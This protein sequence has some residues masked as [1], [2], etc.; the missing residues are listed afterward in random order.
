MHGPALTRAQRRTLLRR[1][2]RARPLENRASWDRASR[3][4]ARLRRTRL[5]CRLRPHRLRGRG[6]NRARS[7]LRHDHATRR[8]LGMR[9]GRRWRDLLCGLRHHRRGRLHC[10]RRRRRRRLRKCGR[11]RRLWRGGLRR[12]NPLRFRLRR[13]NSMHRPHG[14]RHARGRYKTRRRDRRRRCGC[15]SRGDGW[16]GRCNRR[17][18]AHRSLCGDGARRGF[19]RRSGWGWRWRRRS[20]THSGWGWCSDRRRCGRTRGWRRGT[21]RS[22][23]RVLLLGNGLQDIAGTRDS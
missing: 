20:G 21:G 9:R 18:C 16:Y 3:L 8:S 12:R 11:R 10:L 2:L 23:G 19:A 13:R 4:W 1:T 7:R 6:V 22:L 5:R 14:L 17:L 15:W